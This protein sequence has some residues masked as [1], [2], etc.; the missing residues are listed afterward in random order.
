MAYTI[1]AGSMA[2]R[3]LSILG[4]DNAD[5]LD[6]M[7]NLH[8]LWEESIWEIM[9]ALPERLLLTEVDKPID[10]ELCADVDII[11]GD[12]KNIYNHHILLVVRVERLDVDGVAT[13]IRKN[14]QEVPYEE[15]HR[16]LDSDSLYFATKNSPVYW[17]E[18]SASGFRTIKTAP[19]TTGQDAGSTTLDNGKSGIMIFNY[20]RQTIGVTDS[21]DNLGWNNIITPTYVPPTVE[22]IIIKRIALRIIDAK[23]ATTSTQE[24]D[25]EVFNILGGQ[26]QL[27]EQDIKNSLMKIQGLEEK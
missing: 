2:N 10:P 26:K 16:V 21:A 6:D 8:E 3:V 1:A 27:L 15:S 18:P 5:Y 11:P 13:Y 20:P 4:E 17:I 12:D 25:Q 7:E 22:D 19:T 24:E 9:T 14:C 23:I